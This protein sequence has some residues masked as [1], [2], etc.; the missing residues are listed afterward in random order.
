M[1]YERPSTDDD[2]GSVDSLYGES[3]YETADTPDERKLYGEP[4]HETGSEYDEQT[5]YGEP[6]HETRDEDRELPDLDLLFARM[7]AEAPEGPTV[8]SGRSDS[9]PATT[10]Q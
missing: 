1:R 9:S 6:Q 10:E 7:R 2:T 3:S 4:C 5:L 8:L